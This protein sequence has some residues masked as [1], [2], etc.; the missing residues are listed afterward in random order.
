MFIRH[1]FAELAALAWHGYKQNGRGYLR[2]TGYDAEC[3]PA[4]KDIIDISTTPFPGLKEIEY[5]P[6]T[7]LEDPEDY[8][9]ENLADMVE[10]YDARWE[11]VLLIEKESGE[12]WGS[13]R[14][15]GD[16]KPAVAYKHLQDRVQAAI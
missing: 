15:V 7:T 12:G 1:K 9:T 10:T 13:Y 8:P 5:I 11:I 2:V 4:K 16:V 3:F 14:F 6:A